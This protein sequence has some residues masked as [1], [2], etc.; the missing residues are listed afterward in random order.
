[1]R[2]D[3]P[4]AL[5]TSA[6]QGTTVLYVATFDAGG[7]CTDQGWTNV[8]LSA[9][10]GP[11][12]HVDDFN[13]LNSAD[14]A[15]LAGTQSLWCGARPSTTDPL[16]SYVTLPGYGNLWDENFCTRAC[17]PVSGDGLLDVTF[18]ARFDSEG[19]YDATSLEYTLD[20][21]GQTG[22]TRI[23]G[24]LSVWDG[25]IA[26]GWFGGAYPIGSTGPVRI[27]LH[28][29]SDGFW[30]DE[31]GLWDTNG[32]V[33]VD[34]LQAEGLPVEDFEGEAVGATAA[35]DWENCPASGYG[36][37]LTQ[38]HGATL[39]QEDPCVRDITCVWAAIA[40][41]TANYA[42]GGFPAQKA[43][44]FVNADG[45]FQNNEIW[46]PDIPLTGTGA[47]VNLEFSVYRDQPFDN[48]VFYVWRVRTTDPSGCGVGWY[49]RDF[50]FYGGQKDWFRHREPVG[51]LLDLVNGASM[52]VAL[53]VIDQC[54][55]WCGTVG[56]GGGE[57]TPPRI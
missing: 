45:L 42:C 53:G 22:W 24:G 14:Y 13:G 1:V 19:A 10:G 30:S 47:V 18:L 52:N 17:I 21:T 25:V 46:S 39:L 15:A 23:D 12:F 20:C 48:L 41:S 8:D 32:A 16:C 51:D 44:P 3:A 34:S 54:W 57:N 50:L 49:D 2:G 56:S 35:T 40:G 43:V 31:D 5:A 37:A 4:Q 55:I 11:Y 33:V 36:T 29:A 27:R 28:F 38:Q 6:A 7:S 26:A 9:P